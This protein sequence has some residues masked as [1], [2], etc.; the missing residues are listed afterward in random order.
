MK[1]I[2]VGKDGYDM[3]D[4]LGFLGLVACGLGQVR[5]RDRTGSSRV[6]AEGDGKGRW[7]CQRSRWIETRE[8]GGV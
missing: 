5:V 4:E 7:W 1:G 2:E 6:R 3:A 8:D